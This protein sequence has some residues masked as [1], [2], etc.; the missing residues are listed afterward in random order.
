MPA[1]NRRR[2]APPLPRFL[3]SKPRFNSKFPLRSGIYQADVCRLFVQVWVNNAQER[4]C[5]SLFL[6]DKMKAVTN[7]DK[8]RTDDTKP[9]FKRL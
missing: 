3:A 8:E 7:M 6:I 2:R 1:L 9:C 4:T 5:F